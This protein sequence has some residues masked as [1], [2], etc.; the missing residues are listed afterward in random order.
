MLPMHHAVSEKMYGCNIFPEEGMFL[1]YDDVLNI[2]SRTVSKNEPEKPEYLPLGAAFST[3][4][5]LP[6]HSGQ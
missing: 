5:V 4:E 6:K 2:G 1:K 3:C